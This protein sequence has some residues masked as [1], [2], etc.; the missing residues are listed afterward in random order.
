M[1]R[2]KRGGREKRR[3]YENKREIVGER[4]RDRE[5]EGDGD[6]RGRTRHGGHSTAFNRLLMRSNTRNCCFEP[7]IR[8]ASRAQNEMPDGERIIIRTCA[9]E[10]GNHYAVA[11]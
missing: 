6:R 9:A 4:D 11:M 10:M 3:E 5:G 2:G 7:A 1:K 8:N